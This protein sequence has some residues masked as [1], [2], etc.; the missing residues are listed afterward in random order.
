MVTPVPIVERLPN[1]PSVVT[2]S[3][4]QPTYTQNACLLKSL[5][6]SSSAYKSEFAST[7]GARMQQLR[8]AESMPSLQDLVI[9]STA[10]ALKI[11][12]HSEL[13]KDEVAYEIANVCSQITGIDSSLIMSLYEMTVSFITP[14]N[15]RKIRKT[16]LDGTS[17]CF[18]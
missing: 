4:E 1:S 13:G 16:I 18:H 7:V 3:V 8:D 12:K 5:P 15:L 17:K 11:F 6:K 14:K 2:A 10:I 9:E